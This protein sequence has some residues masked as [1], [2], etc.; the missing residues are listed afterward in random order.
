[1]VVAT[2]QMIMTPLMETGATI[3]TNCGK[4]VNK[5]SLTL[6]VKIVPSRAQ[7][8]MQKNLK[9]KLLSL[10]QDMRLG[11][12]RNRHRNTRRKSKAETER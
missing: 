2:I 1:M 3:G 11:R 4:K 7:M 10:E 6:A 5:K 9:E 8:K 12:V